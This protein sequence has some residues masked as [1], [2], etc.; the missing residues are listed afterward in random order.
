MHWKLLGDRNARSYLLVFD[1]GDEIIETLTAFAAEQHLTCARFQA[2]GG[3]DRATI[4]FWN[5]DTKRYEPIG[6][7]GQVEVLSLLGDIAASSQG[8]KVHA[9]AVLGHRSGATSGGH[10]LKGYVR[11]T[12]E[13]FLTDSG[14]EVVRELDAATGLYLIR[15]Q[16]T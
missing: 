13:L 16:R 15:L 8:P 10:L 2:I 12:L 3:L 1:T 6:V 9:H 5:W 14:D 11:P 7:D 4:A